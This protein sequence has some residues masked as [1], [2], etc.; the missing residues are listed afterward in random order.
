MLE[1]GVP[2]FTGYCSMVISSPRFSVNSRDA[3]SLEPSRHSTGQAAGSL[4]VPGK[5]QAICL[6][7]RDL[8][9]PHQRCSPNPLLSTGVGVGSNNYVVLVQW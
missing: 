5:G 6:N 4:P 2:S 1:E 8:Q 7:A 9:L 3:Q